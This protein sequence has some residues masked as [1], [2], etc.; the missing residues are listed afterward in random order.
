MTIT[1][2]LFRTTGDGLATKQYVDDNAGGGGSST[3]YWNMNVGFNYSISTVN[4]RCYLPITGNI[5]ES[6]NYH[7]RNEYQVAVM[8]HDGYLQKVVMRSE[9]ACGSTVV[10]MH[11]SSDGTETPSNTASHSVTVDMATDDTAYT[12]TF[13]DSA[14]FSKGQVVAFTFDPTNDANDTIGTL[15]FILDGST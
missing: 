1:K 4:D 5:Y 6:H 13:G 7:G 9:E 10:G 2:H 14:S 8:P 15:V 12:F 3:Y 11:L